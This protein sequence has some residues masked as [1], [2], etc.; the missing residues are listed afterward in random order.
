MNSN[1]LK[2]LADFQFV[3]TTFLKNLKESYEAKLTLVHNGGM[4]LATPNLIAF[5]NSW[6]EPQIFVEDIYQK[7]ILVNRL[8]LLNQA[9]S[10]YL[11]AMT[12]W[13]DEVKQSNRIRQVK[14]V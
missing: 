14:D 13:F 8:D 11:E 4:F 5:L 6:G 9:K 12:F 2:D 10:V 7:P 1:E 3:R